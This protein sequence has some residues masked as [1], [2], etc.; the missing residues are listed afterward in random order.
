MPTMETTGGASNNF[1]N[2]APYK[3]LSNVVAATAGGLPQVLS[4]ATYPALA[5]LLARGAA[6]VL[7]GAGIW[8]YRPTQ[9][10]KILQ[11]S[12]FSV[13]GVA[14]QTATYDIGLYPKL[15][16]GGLSVFGKRHRAVLTV[17]AL[18][19]AAQV[20][21]PFNG[22]T[23][24]ASQALQQYDTVSWTYRDTGDL[25]VYDKGFAAGGSGSIFVDMSFFDMIAITLQ[26]KPASSTQEFVGMLEETS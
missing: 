22:G 10:S 3:L 12:F 23:V 5:T 1:R 24:F 14:A 9:G 2:C 18:A 7:L 25:Q 26:A 6:P 8:A 17:G 11:L 21:D 16:D 4:V 15:A 19:I 20:T 13:A